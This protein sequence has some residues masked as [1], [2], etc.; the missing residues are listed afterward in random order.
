MAS[1]TIVTVYVPNHR[2]RRKSRTVEDFGSHVQEIIADLKETL[3]VSD[4]GIGLAA[5][6]VGVLRRIFVMQLDP[7]TPVKA[8]INPEVLSHEDYAYFTEGCLSIPGFNAKVKRPYR[9]HVRYQDEEGKVHEETLE[10]LPAR[11]FLHE[12]DHLNG[13][14]FLDRAEEGTILNPDHEEAS[15]EEYEFVI[16]PEEEFLYSYAPDAELKKIG[17]EDAEADEDFDA[18]DA[19][20]D[21]ESA[22]A[23]EPTP[24]AGA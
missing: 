23:T 5:P 9:I 19:E 11:C 13:I 6:Q 18:A 15:P 8:Y 2:L 17:L 24:D 14:L 12:F 20:T 21:E 10:D 3:E 22:D 4:D 16:T 1:R 7:N